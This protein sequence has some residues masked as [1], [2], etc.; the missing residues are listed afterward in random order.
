MT[1]HP[2]PLRVGALAVVVVAAGWFQAA[3]TA[4]AL[5]P[6]EPLRVAFA[7]DVMPGL[8]PSE[9]EASI[10]VWAMELARGR[11]IALQATTKVYGELDALEKDMAAGRVHLVTMTTQRYWRLRTPA[12]GTVLVGQRH[13]HVGQEVLLLVRKDGGIRTLADLRGRSL[14]VLE[15]GGEGMARA[16]LDLLL[17][18]QGMGD[19]ASFFGATYSVPKANRAALPVFF[20]QR[21]AC[22]LT[23]GAF[24]TIAELNPQLGTALS[25]VA[26]SPP[27]QHSLVLVGA[28][29]DPATRPAVLDALL[30]LH[31][32]PR[33]QQVL[34]LFGRE[35]LVVGTAADLLPT[36]QLLDRLARLRQG[37]PRR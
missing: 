36:L 30:N 15:G 11:G 18:E 29:Y 37:S 1:A 22:L 26:T 6:A 25:A 7:S 12:F 13:G 4:Q 19:T 3:A 8:S 16:W 2:G 21:D 32:T 23:K 14:M 31:Q 20:G 28:Q 34:S 27:L 10:E 17:L 33:G 24:D 9:A 35:R 5:R